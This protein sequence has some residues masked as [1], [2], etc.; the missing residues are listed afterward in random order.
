[1]ALLCSTRIVVKS[2]D[3]SG[4]DWFEKAAQNG[5]AKS[6]FALAEV[7]ANGI[8]VRSNH[9]KAA[10]LYLDVHAHT[11]H[12]CTHT[13]TCSC[14]CRYLRS[15]EHGCVYA[16]LH[17]GMCLEDGVGIDANES[18]A[19]LWYERAADTGYPCLAI[20][21]STHARTCALMHV[22]AHRYGRAMHQLGLCLL[23]SSNEK[24]KGE[25]FG[26]LY[27]AVG[28]GES[29]ASHQ[30]GLCYRDGI[31]VKSDKERGF[32]HF[33]QAATHACTHALMRTHA[34]TKAYTQIC[35]AARLSAMLFDR[36]PRW[37]IY[38]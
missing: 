12:A 26:W 27:K 4:L 23:K 1:M 7:Y 17:R 21:V 22:R 36:R 2:E 35:T 16:Q 33:G 15:A 38:Y 10:E 32:F 3:G 34:H 5:H 37:V 18:E 28:A 31:G 25:G 6:E 9:A 19:L 30:L 29:K 14:A 13:R 24:R 8:G 20:H 11:S